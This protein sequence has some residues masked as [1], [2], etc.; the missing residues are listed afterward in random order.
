VEA[1]V[2]DRRIGGHKACRYAGVRVPGFGVTPERSRGVTR[3]SHVPAAM[4]PGIE[5]REPGKNRPF[6]LQITES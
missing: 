5:E 2:S 3:S 4:S 1:L 6:R